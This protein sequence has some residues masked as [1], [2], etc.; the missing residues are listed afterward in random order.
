MAKKD[1]PAYPGYRLWVSAYRQLPVIRMNIVVGHSIHSANFYGRRPG[2]VYKNQPA[3]KFVEDELISIS[4]AR[5]ANTGSFVGRK[6]A[7]YVKQLYEYSSNYHPDSVASEFYYALR[8]DRFLD[9]RANTDLD[10]IKNFSSRWAGSPGFF[11]TLTSFLQMN[12]RRGRIVL[13]SSRFGPDMKSLMSKYDL[14]YMVALSDSGN[15]FMGVTDVFSPAF[16]IPYYYENTPDAIRVDNKGR[17]KIILVPGTDSEQNS[18]TEKLVISPS[19]SSGALQVKRTSTLTGH[20]KSGVQQDLVLF[21]DYYEHERKLLGIKKTLLEDFEDTRRTK[22]Y[23]DE[24][25]A[26]F[27]EARKNQKDAFEKEAKTWFATEINDLT[28]HT[29]VNLGVRHNSPDF[30]YSSSFSIPGLVKKAGNNFTIDV[31]R[32]LGAPI[33]IEESQR[34]RTLN[35]YAPYASSVHHRISIEIPAGYTAEGIASL[36]RKVENETGAFIA[37]AFTDGKTVTINVSRIFRHATEPSANWDKM[38]AFIDA[39]VEWSNAKLLLKKQ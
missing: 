6:V 14:G 31:G 24:L 34:K 12:H 11:Y 29:V 22:N 19:L 37:E 38:L 32:M 5:E 26:A 10:Y 2:V 1:V 36:N 21:E 3:S 30:I 25:K 35:V 15:L 18:R 7:S 8:F 23:G 16:H 9:L 17:Q 33:K 27:A 4:I 13:L 39:S 20:Y 28:D